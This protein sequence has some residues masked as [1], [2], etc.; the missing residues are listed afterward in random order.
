[1]K[2]VIPLIVSLLVLEGYSQCIFSTNTLWEGLYPDDIELN[3]PFFRRE[4]TWSY[5]DRGD[6]VEAS[7]PATIFGNVIQPLD[8]TLYVIDY[9]TA[10]NQP[11]ITVCDPSIKGH[12]K[13]NWR[14]DC[15]AVIFTLI[16]DACTS[17]SARY[18]G[19]TLSRDSNP[20]TGICG[21]Q[22]G[23]L[24]DSR[25]VI[26]TTENAASS[27]YGGNNDYIHW[28]PEGRLFLNYHFDNATTVILTEH[29]STP[30]SFGCKNTSGTY[31][32]E[33]LTCDAVKYHLVSD[34]CLTR[35][36]LY[37]GIVFWRRGTPEPII[38][39]TPP[40]PNIVAKTKVVVNLNFDGIVPAKSYCLCGSP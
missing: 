26:G 3:N 5:G 10:P 35:I 11:N 20:E 17:R 16:T 27:T 36:V 6:F 15:G 29:F 4:F 32:V 13:L 19:V 28:T 12:Y 31:V 23:D 18:S 39:P 33:Y 40:P 2:W 1:M 21:F 25:P 24:F 37:D 8:G 9:G 22:I 34:A 7:T 14:G 38:E 30:A